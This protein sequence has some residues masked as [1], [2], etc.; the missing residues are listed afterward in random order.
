[1]FNGFGLYITLLTQKSLV[2][3]FIQYTEEYSVCQWEPFYLFVFIGDLMLTALSTWLTLHKCI[4]RTLLFP[5]IRS[6]PQIT[7]QWNLQSTYS[8]ILIFCLSLHP[9][10]CFLT[11]ITIEC[12]GNLLFRIWLSCW[13]VWHREQE[14]CFWP[15]LFSWR[16]WQWWAAART[17]KCTY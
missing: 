2:S 5:E 11:L 3:F 14:L 10:W 7:H 9:A 17:S 6:L 8:T 15:L 13:N 16:L 1:M 12:S 4:Y